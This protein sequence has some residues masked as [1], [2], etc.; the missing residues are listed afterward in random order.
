MTGL[1]SVYSSFRSAF[2]L[3][4]ERCRARVHLR[5]CGM[6]CWQGR[7][8][9]DRQR[10]SRSETRSRVLQPH[11]W[12]ARRYSMVPQ[13]GALGNEWWL[14]RTMLHWVC[15]DGGGC[16]A[17]RLRSGSRALLRLEDDRGGDRAQ[18]LW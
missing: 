10:R 14:R 9:K 15:Q 7:R 16:G 18:A 8:A 12:T 1:P 3:E 2:G 17:N 6:R 4:R 5:R 13:F 11:I